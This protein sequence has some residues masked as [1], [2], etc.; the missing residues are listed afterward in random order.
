[1]NIV[2]DQVLYSNKGVLYLR[3]FV[4][5]KISLLFQKVFQ[6][7]FLLDSSFKLGFVFSFQSHEVIFQEF[8]IC[9]EKIFARDLS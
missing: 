8:L 2:T 3:S 1:M 4:S 9:I 5:S 7:T 6:K